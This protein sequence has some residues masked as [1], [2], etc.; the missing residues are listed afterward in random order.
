VEVHPSHAEEV[1]L[2]I[3]LKGEVVIEDAN[4]LPEVRRTGDDEIVVI[5]ADTGKRRLTR[6]RDENRKQQSYQGCNEVAHLKHPD[7]GARATSYRS[8]GPIQTNFYLKVKIPG[9]LSSLAFAVHF[10]YNCAF[11]K[12]CCSQG[13]SWTK[14]PA[15]APPQALRS[16]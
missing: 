6:R 14:Q 15:P 10:P 11:D 13:K 5:P 3:A 4:I 7:Q 9:P 2:K 12:G 8:N 1:C 16:I